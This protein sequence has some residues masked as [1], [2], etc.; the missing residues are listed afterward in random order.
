M[1][2]FFIDPMSYNNLEE[3]DYSL[4]SNIDTSFKVYFFGSNK[5]KTTTSLFKRYLIFNYS[6]YSNNL[7]KSILYIYSILKLLLLYIYYRPNIVH[8]QWFKIPKLDYVILRIYKL[9][10]PAVKIVFTAHNILPHNS[11][12]KFLNIYLK[13]YQFVDS[14]IV[15]DRKSVV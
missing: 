3:Y 8:I 9:I 15:Q 12:N 4:I 11:G 13:I 14:I 7:L 1:K 6:N 2:I 10:N 5:F